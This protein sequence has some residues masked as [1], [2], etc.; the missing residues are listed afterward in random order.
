[1][2]KRVVIIDDDEACRFLYRHHFRGIS[3]IEII[4]EF[5]NAEEALVQIPVLK[6]DVVIVDYA[7]PGMSGVKLTEQLS[8]YPEIRVLLA[9]GH[10]PEHL[11][12]L[13]KSSR[14]FDVVCK[15][16]SKESLKR[17]MDF[18]KWRHPV[19]EG[20]RQNRGPSA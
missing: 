5:E 8:R 2:P 18:C 19:A 13:P 15:D 4:G 17:I 20:P 1:M 9:T 12:S 10:N 3:G 11:A 14:S 16:W 6:P 7:L